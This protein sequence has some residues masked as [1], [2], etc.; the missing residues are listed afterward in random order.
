[1]RSRDSSPGCF[2]RSE[3]ARNERESP[4]S[5]TMSERTGLFV[6]RLR[7]SRVKLTFSN[8][9]GPVGKTRGAARQPVFDGVL[10]VGHG[11]LLEVVAHVGETIAEALHELGPDRVGR[12]TLFELQLREL[13]TRGIEFFFRLHGAGD[14]A[15]ELFTLGRI[16]RPHKTEIA[17]GLARGV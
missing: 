9:V 3:G 5:A 14:L 2:S 16:R 8:Q 6:L 7:G 11:P 4:G 13:V 10:Q 15:F 1:T 12:F 17:P